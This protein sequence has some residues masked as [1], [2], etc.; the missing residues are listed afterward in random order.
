VDLTGVTSI[1]A[2]GHVF[3]F[4]LPGPV[5][6]PLLPEPPI[7]PIVEVTPPPGEALT[8][9]VTLTASSGSAVAV[10]SADGTPGGGVAAGEEAASS[11]GG[12][13]VAGAAA[14]SSQPAWALGLVAAPAGAAPTEAGP[15]ADTGGE[16]GREPA[17]ESA[18]PKPA[19]D[20]LDLEKQ[21]REQD[22]Y[23]PTPD[24]DRPG[25]LS[26]RREGSRRPSLIAQAPAVPAAVPEV[27]EPPRWWAERAEVVEA[28]VAR[29][30]AAPPTDAA[31]DAA[32]VLGS[33][34]SGQGWRLLG[35]AGLALYPWPQGHP[36]PEREGRDKPM[37]KSPAPIR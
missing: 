32:F 31:T 28:V 29:F 3:E 21:L 11:G 22:L 19:E 15:A 14:G 25:P 24:P 8:V 6:S 9:V 2:A 23:R 4:L 13:A 18:P 36:Q 5:G 1:D 16:E 20:G 17:S 35:L 34:W 37:R 10:A 30:R 27:G 26:G 7:G 33:S 12:A